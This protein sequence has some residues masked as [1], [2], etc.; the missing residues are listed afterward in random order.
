MFSKT[1][2]N[3]FFDQTIKYQN[4]KSLRQRVEDTGLKRNGTTK[5]NGPQVN[6]QFAYLINY[7]P[8]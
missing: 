3:F 1:V 5:S 8:R 7:F 6:A 4:D 2:Q